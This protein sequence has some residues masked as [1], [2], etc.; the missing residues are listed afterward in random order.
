MILQTIYTLAVSVTQ[1]PVPRDLQLPL[2]LTSWELE[3]ALVALFLLHIIFVN[4]MVGGSIFSVFF[5]ILGLF[6]PKYDKLA[7]RIAHTITVNKSLAVVLGVGPLLCI[8]L[9]Y[10]IQFYA[11]NAL[12][13]HAWIAVI[14]L[15][16]IA[17]LLAYLH[18][19]TWDRWTGS[20]KNYHIVVGSAATFLFLCIP[21]IFLANINLMLF[22]ERWTQIQ[23]FFSSLEIGNVFPRFFH[24]LSASLAF[25]GLFLAGWF[26]R[27]SFPLET[28][29]PEFTRPELRR[30]FYRF[31]FFLT[32]AQLAFGPLLF[33]TLPAGGLTLDLLLVITGGILM[34]LFAL[35][36]IWRE[37]RAE[38]SLIG[39]HY[40]LIWTVFGCVVVFMATGRHLYREACV[41][42]HRQAIAERTERFLTVQGGD[43]DAPGGRSWSG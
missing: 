12:T 37:I 26:G 1:T 43:P 39:R 29:L 40:I 5:E 41:D 34:A 25:T 42:P 14:P 28:L 7:Q 33:V 16:S 11:A 27:K 30:L 17:F 6:W 31:A 19:Y 20:L 13:G 38:D 9:L 18:K 8:S 2:P 23:G 4:L 22:P 32:I 36:L 10:T 21:L 15:V 35:T 24:F 3:V